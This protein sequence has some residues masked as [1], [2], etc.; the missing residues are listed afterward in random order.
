MKIRPIQARIMQTIHPLAVIK[1]RGERKETIKEKTNFTPK[2]K[3]RRTMI[4][5]KNK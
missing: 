2:I 4:L 3:S 1:T 5:A